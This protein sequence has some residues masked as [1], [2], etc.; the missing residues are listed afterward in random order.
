MLALDAMSQ[1][2]RAMAWNVCSEPL[3]HGNRSFLIFQMMV[4][5][6]IAILI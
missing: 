5:N 2:I 4:I 6:N 1:K 3:A